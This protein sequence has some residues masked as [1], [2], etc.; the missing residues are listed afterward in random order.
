MCG[1]IGIASNK[2]VTSVLV[3]GLHQMEYR[4]YDSAGLC[5]FNNELI[6]KRVKGRVKKLEEKMTS[7][8]DAVHEV[9]KKYQTTF[10]NAA[11]IL[12]AARIKEKLK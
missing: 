1:I 11:Y 7:A 9:Q 5:V 3:N 8:F 12:A 10:R 2:D 6:A 4:G